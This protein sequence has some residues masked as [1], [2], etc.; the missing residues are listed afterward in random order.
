MGYKEVYDGWQADPEG[1]WMEVA[2]AID[3]ETAPTKALTDRG[4]GL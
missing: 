4:E 3:W 1:F 2:Q